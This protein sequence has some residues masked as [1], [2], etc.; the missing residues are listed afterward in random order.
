M[1]MSRQVCEKLRI[2][3]NTGEVAYMSAYNGG[4]VEGNSFRI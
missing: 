2:N 1:E 3:N 4:S